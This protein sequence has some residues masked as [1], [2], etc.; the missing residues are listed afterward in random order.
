[1]ASTLQE[2]RALPKGLRLFDSTGADGWRLR[3]YAWPA[4]QPPRGSLLFQTGRGDFVE[5][6]IEALAHWHA[7][8]WNIGGFDWRGQ[9]GSARE[10]PGDVNELDAMVCD[11]ADYVKRWTAEMPG[12]HVFVGH[13]MGGHLLLRLLVE[14]RVVVDA[15]VLVSPMLGLAHAPLP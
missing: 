15:A 9:G 2:R 8:G 6:Y 10:G 4:G 1:M 14:H 7:S 12:P 13:S 11:A 3:A 5:K